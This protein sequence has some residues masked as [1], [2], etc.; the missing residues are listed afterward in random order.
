MSLLDHY[1]VEFSRQS[2]ALYAT[3][4]DLTI[5]GGEW[6][7]GITEI[8]GATA[9]LRRDANA[10]PG[11]HGGRPIYHGLEESD[12]KIR[13]I[14]WTNDQIKKLWELRQLLVP[15]PGGTPKNLSLVSAWTEWSGINAVAVRGSTDFQRYSGQRVNHGLQIT[16]TASRWLGA[17]K[18]AN[19]V[20]TVQPKRTYQTTR[21][22]ADPA[23]VSS[24]PTSQSGA[25]G[26]PAS[27]SR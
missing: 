21:P 1:F 20:V 5:L 16:I 17:A 2:G 13:V 22:F 11:S 7:P 10:K 23:K 6:L 12:L 27:V 19:K 15:L 25:C 3:G 26:P 9:Q 24:Q 14:V 8:D 4:A 18:A